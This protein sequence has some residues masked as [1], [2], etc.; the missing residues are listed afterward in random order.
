MQLTVGFSEGAGYV[1]NWPA[2]CARAVGLYR[3]EGLVV[4]LLVQPEAEQTADLVSGKLAIA[5]RGA[6]THFNLVEEG[7]PVRTIAGLLRKAPLYLYARDGITDVAALRGRTIAANSSIAGSFV[8]RMALADAAIGDGDWTP[9]GTGGARTRLRALID[10]RADA[11]LLSPPNTVEA[12]GA[13]FRLLLSV[14]QHYPHLLYSTIQVRTDFA[15]T[16]GDALV[17]MLRAD[18][19][20]QRWLYDPANRDAAIAILSEAYALSEAHARACY[21]ALVTRDRV[22]C[23]HA[24]L[25]REALEVIADGLARF[26]R[27]RR[28]RPLDDY[29]DPRFLAEAER[30]L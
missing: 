19:R 3:D 20:A 9:L 29:L 11:A 22:Y 8:L 18:I 14:P 6:D 5:R 1:L 17:R 23:T 13:G 28:D 2:L 24:E 27:L 21:D 12:E 4:E 16:A 15:A 26:G 10:G 30:T 7:V 25:D